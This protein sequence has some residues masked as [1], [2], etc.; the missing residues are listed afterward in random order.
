[1][2]GFD[3]LAPDLPLFENRFLE[4]SAGT[5]KTFA[6]ENLV[7]RLLQEGIP[8]NE[9]LVVTFT[10]AATIELKERIRAHL[11]TEQL[12][13][14]DEAKIWT[15]HSFCF[16]CLQEHALQTGFSL[17]Q[18][19]ES[20]QADLLKEIIKDFLRTATVLSPKQLEKVL[21]DR[22]LDRIFGLVSQR[23]PIEPP[24]WNF[25]RFEVDPDKLLEDLLALAPQYGKL[26]GKQKQ[27]KPEILEGL[28]RFTR[29]I[30]GEPV[31][32][33]DFPI[34]KFT[35]ENALKRTV[36]P[37]LNYPGLLEEFQLDLIPKLASFSNPEHILA[38]LAE[39]ARLHAE[40]VIEEE[41]LVFF[42]D[43]LRKMAKQTADPAF[44]QTVRRQY[45]AV[46][47]DEFQ[48][49]DPLQWKI[50]STLFLTEEFKGPVYL[51]GDP[52]QSI[53]RFR[54]AD[55]Y[56]Y[57][58]AKKTMGEKSHAS[59]QTNYRST[60]SL[61]Q[62]LNILFSKDF[63]TLPK[64]GET[65][66]SPPVE[67]A[68]RLK[69]IA[70]GK[71]SLHFLIAENEE[72][73]FST[74]VHE[75]ARLDLPLRECAVL[76]SDRHQAER[77]MNACPLPAVSKRSRSLLDSPAFETLLELIRAAQNPRDRS[78]MA[79]VLGGPLFGYPL[80]EI[81]EEFERFYR[82]RRLL[83]SE[84]ILALFQAAAADSNLSDARLY[85]D[86]M[87][88]VEM[89]VH[90]KEDYLSFYQ[91]L[92]RLD[93]EAERL[94]AR[95]AAEEEAI[96]VMTIHVSKG[97]EFSVVFPI[98]IA[99]P[100][101]KH[102]GLVRCENRL[103]LSDPLSEAEERSEKMR[104]LYVAC[105]RAKQR[106]YVPVLKNDSPISAFL[107]NADFSAAS[108]EVC[109]LYPPPVFSKKEAPVQREIQLDKT[110]PP[111]AIHSYSSIV[112]YEPAEKRSIPEGIMPAGQE[113]G[114]LIHQLFENFSFG[115][116]EI[117]SF[118]QKELQ[119]TFLESWTSEAASMMEWALNHPLPAPD[120]SFPLAAVDPKK[121]IKEMEFLFPSE[122][123]PGFFKGFVDLFFEH[124]G[125]YY[126]I[127]WKTNIVDTSV[128]E[129][130][131]T[132][133][134]DVQAA[135]YQNAAE[136][137]LKLFDDEIRF[138][139]AFYLFLRPSIVYFFFNKINLSL[140]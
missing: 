35:E 41:D 129:V 5:G 127:D 66:S 13:Q 86:M 22:L 98:G 44:A 100:F 65:I 62:E 89:G 134:Y 74:I 48:D 12:V 101:K 39:E 32:P 113:T 70:D 25:P 79:R 1:M 77:F 106:V 20:G 33:V 42:E 138:K 19:E 82:Y 51:V 76:V 117:H 72:V 137:Y 132:H 124:E 38:V 45:Q 31:D 122:E 115:N 87:Q 52:K 27:V 78:A 61:V 102:K 49:T 3:V 104:Q 95:A 90:I 118:V 121:M 28:K 58:E 63:I 119:G 24:D 9:I 128:E 81:P 47:I 126:F 91:G 83:E 36:S 135:I 14:F 103:A 53:Y 34:V 111:L 57:M 99:T 136:R 40:R 84:G 73:L 133:H 69:P 18:I 6:I 110:Y 75:I 11:P 112:A 130:I 16:H 139:G 8:L 131:R 30:G 26:C 107:E 29:W 114:V 64:T 4:A 59:L 93:P 50:F 7:V 43:L 109:R 10:R 23:L 2:R 80:N 21:N 56:T 125:G 88:L 71:G 92:M 108:Q 123:P 116:A 140:K 94:R 60:P 68:S 17:D 120:G 54:G 67:A 46:L 15:I 85:Q 55:L 37:S 97:L 105:T 96:Q